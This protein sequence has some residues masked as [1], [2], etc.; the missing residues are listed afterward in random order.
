MILPVA[1]KPSDPA[2][3]FCQWV[4]ARPHQVKRDSLRQDA[5]LLSVLER[6]AVPMD[7]Y[8]N[9][10]QITSV[11]GPF[12]T[13]WGI[14][15]D[16][17]DLILELYF[18]DYTREEKK[19]SP[20]EVLPHLELSPIA[21]KIPPRSTY[22][23]WSVEMNLKT[24]AVADQID[25]YASGVGGT[26]SAGICYS[27]GREGIQLKN[28]YSF[29]ESRN[30]VQLILEALASSPRLSGAVQQ[31]EFLRPG[32]MSEEVFVY[33]QKQQTDAIYFSRVSVA[34]AIKAI[35][36]WKRADLFRETFGLLQENICHH[37]F[38]VG[39][40]VVPCTEH[41]ANVQRVGIYGIM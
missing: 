18:Y 36:L 33:S 11:V 29:F 31:C 37:L 20:V 41:G 16:G 35:K 6:A 25:V 13:V 24:A 9:L 7:V 23:M 2:R 1:S 32:F 12:N 19:F 39:I 28:L 14:K 8:A 10:A 5:F 15:S 26:I 22:F 21:S 38:D 27:V 34:S 17:T 3:D 40:D 30:D 4:Y